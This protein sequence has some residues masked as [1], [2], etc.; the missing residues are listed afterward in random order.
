MLVWDDQVRIGCPREKLRRLQKHLRSLTGMPAGIE[1]HAALVAALIQAGELIQGIADALFADRGCDAR[2]DA[3]AAAMALLARLAAAVRASWDSGF[4]RLYVPP[5]AQIRALAATA[6][7]MTVE[8]KR[9]EGFALYSLYPE[10]YLEAAARASLHAGP[11]I[12]V[13]GI[14]TIGA[15]LG[16]L[17]AATL[18]APPPVTLRPVG[19]RPHFRVAVAKQLAAE[20]LADA[21]S[22]RFAVVDEGP[23]L[24]G[25]S[26]GAVADFLE[27]RGASPERIHFFA[28]HRGP[29]APCARSRHR[30]RWTRVTPHVVEL[31]DLLIHS[32]RR[33]EH[34]LERWVADLV[35]EPEAPLEEISGGR[36]RRLR[37]RREADWPASNPYLERRKFLLRTGEGAWLLKFAG[38]GPEGARKLHRA[39]ALHAAGLTP[40]VRGY[41]HG[42]LVERWQ[43]ELPSLD[44]ACGER[45]RL[46][47]QVG[48]YL[49]FRARHFPAAVERGA[50]LA[51]LWGMARYNAGLALGEKVARRLDRFAPML[52]RLGR[53]VRPIET[54]NRTHAWEWLLAPDGRLLKTDA[55]DHHAAH[56]FVGCQDVAWD[57][58]GAAIELGLSLSERDRLCAMVEAER[59]RHLDPDL[60]ALLAPCYLA[61][62]LG[63]FALSTEIAADQP[64]E[65]HRLRAAAA[66]YRDRLRQELLPGG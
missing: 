32:P 20:L 56:D 28:S 1:R 55:L 44:R 25:S 15:P 48:R 13:I 8:I 65:A 5:E 14:R 24:S 29:L 38:L 54:D 16:A 53:R 35:G 30:R 21:A 23:G 7:P 66:R 46:V 26:F 33:P 47:A 3:G 57:V 62:Q 60:L 19:K 49:G 52:E 63:D 11:P 51:R 22:A 34:R 43:G 2:S 6:L 42:F 39:R 37:Y 18:G 64:S 36:W 9:A 31:G 45:E 10:S 12:R 41:R 58:A 27:D 17:V 61:L 4:A 50:S 40:E 59:G